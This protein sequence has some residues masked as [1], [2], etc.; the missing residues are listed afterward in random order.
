MS[1]ERPHMNKIQEILRLHFLNHQ[2]RNAIDR[3]LACIRASVSEYLRRARET[4]LSNWDEVCALSEKELK[5]R[6]GHLPHMR[7][8]RLV[9]PPIDYAYVH[10]ERKRTGITLLVFWNEYRESHPDGLRLHA[11]L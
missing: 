8:P 11:I 5:R 7:R 4:G 10:A 9:R 6:L 3:I 2:S 1:R